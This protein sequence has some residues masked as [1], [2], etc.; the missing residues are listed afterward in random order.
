M[1]FLQIIKKDFQ[2][3]FGQEWPVWVGGIMIGLLNVFLFIFYQP[4]TTLDGILNWGQWLLGSNGLGLIMAEPLPILERSGSVINFG[5]LFGAFLAALLAGQFGIRIGTVRE[6]V[7][8]LIGGVLIGIG[9]V[10]V[11]GCNI[12]G[13]F[14]GSSALGLQGM[15]MAV[16]LTI[17][18]YFGVRYLV[19]EMNSTSLEGKNFGGLKLTAKTQSYMSVVVAGGLIYAMFK[20]A[21]DPRLFD[22]ALILF[23][24]IL[25]GI[26]SQRSRICFV[27]AFREPFLTGD[28]SHTKAMLLALAIS[29]SGITLVKFVLWDRVDDFVRPSFW[30]GSLVGG[31]IFGYGMVMAG[32]CGGGTI[33]RV[34]EGHVKLW[35][36][37]AGYIFTAAYFDNWLAS[38]GLA[39]QLGDPVFLPDMFRTWG[40][41]NEW[42][43]VG[44][45]WILSL[46]AMFL[47]MTLWYLAAHWNQTT[48]KFTA[49][50]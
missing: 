38:S 35:M 22:R 24:G 26:I 36:T 18:A 10:L 28:A 3:I 20:Y 42:A 17:G 41:N 44:D 45:G 8:G 46:L 21:N 6:L 2:T 50:F 29:L 49:L 16:G 43:W 12:G 5:L 14:S 7:K 19:W 9:A 23:F 32:G 48:K 25:L 33:W 30:V 31:I 37:L 34:G 47:I 1:T 15:T 39:Q 11:R 40:L 27:R 4:W 13:F